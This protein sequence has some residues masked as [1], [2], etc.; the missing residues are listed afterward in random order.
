MT[1]GTGSVDPW[2]RSLAEEARFGVRDRIGTAHL[3]DDAARLR[4]ADAIAVGSAVSIARPVTETPSWFGSGTANAVQLTYEERPGFDG[5]VI[6]SDQ[7][8]LEPH[9]ALNTHLVALNHV[10]MD[11]HWYS[12]WDLTEQADVGSLS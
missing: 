10:G 12:N 4:A 1:A 7:V 2:I 6:G 3:I 11:H 9:G 8:V 5:F